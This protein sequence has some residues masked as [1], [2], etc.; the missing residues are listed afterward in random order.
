MLPTNAV[1]S[2]QCG[3]IDAEVSRI[4]AVSGFEHHTEV[5]LLVYQNTQSFEPWSSGWL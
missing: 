1:T 3:S 2:D 5:L 4:S